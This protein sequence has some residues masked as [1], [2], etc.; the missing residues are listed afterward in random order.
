MT[1]PLTFFGSVHRREFFEDIHI[2]LQGDI[3]PARHR[4]VNDRY[5]SASHANMGGRDDSKTYA[6]AIQPC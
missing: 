1:L 3:A 2:S 4:K 5:E 6:A